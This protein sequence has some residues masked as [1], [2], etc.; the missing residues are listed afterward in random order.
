MI[1]LRW[2]AAGIGVVLLQWL[3]FGR[4]PL[5]GVVPDV[6]LLYVAMAALKRGRLVGAATG[7]GAGLLM[8]LLV[9]PATLGLNALLKTVMGYVV[10]VF[11]SEQGENTRLD[12]GQAALGAL[13]I[14]VVHNGLLTIL[15]ALDEGTRTPF[16]IAGLWIGG[17]LYTGLV[18]LVGALLRRRG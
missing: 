4:L 2:A 15:L 10:G 11:R 9:N 14:A 13:V 6:V 3:V 17:A 5:W 18:A 16:L 7:F 8:D 12:A 1:F